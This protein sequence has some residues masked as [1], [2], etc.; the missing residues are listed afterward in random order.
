MGPGSAFVSVMRNVPACFAVNHIV[1]VPVGY[2][3]LGVHPDA[4]F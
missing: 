1:V 2:T 4:S 3:V